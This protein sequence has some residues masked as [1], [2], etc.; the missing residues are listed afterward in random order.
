M[1]RLSWNV[2]YATVNEHNMSDEKKTTPNLPPA[3][4]APSIR[5]TREYLSSLREAV[6]LHIDPETAEVMW[7]YGQ[8]MDPYGGEPNL[9]DE[10]YQ[11][12]RE[13]FARSPGSNIWINFSD[14]PE[15]T[16][17]KLW[18]R[19]K[20]KLAFPTGFFDVEDQKE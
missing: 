7:T 16:E 11:V 8:T 17:T 12:G 2:T 14:L 5:V 3:C 20:S 13:Y 4:V 10:Y 9:P 19:H 15:A 18:E 1:R 6:G